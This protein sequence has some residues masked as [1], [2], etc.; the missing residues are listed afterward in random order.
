MPALVSPKLIAREEKAHAVK[1]FLAQKQNVQ[2]TEGDNGAKR[3]PGRPPVKKST[4]ILPDNVQ[5]QSPDTSFSIPY[6]SEV[7]VP[8]SETISES[9]VQES[10]LS[11]IQE[12]EDRPEVKAPPPLINLPNDAIVAPDGKMITREGALIVLKQVSERLGIQKAA[13][14]VKSVGAESISKVAEEKLH[15]LFDLC[16]TALLEAPPV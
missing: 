4:V 14:L 5:V 7:P 11:T 2:V 13:E 15:E 1:E 16:H 6:R 9:P 8:V 12:A 3:K 10:E